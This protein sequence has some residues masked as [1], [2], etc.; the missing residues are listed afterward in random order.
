MN[1][2]TGVAD[3]ATK[4]YKLRE[5]GD[6]LKVPAD[7]REACVRELL[8]ALCLTEFAGGTETLGPVDFVWVDDG[9]TSVSITDGTGE[10]VLSLKVTTE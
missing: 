10:P 3:A 9:Q 8:Y 4:T 2:E 7:R 1:D 6:L 5:L